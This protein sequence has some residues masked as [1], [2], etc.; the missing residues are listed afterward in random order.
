MN[1]NDWI[2]NRHP[3]IHDEVDGMVEVL[4]GDQLD[5]KIYS[6]KSDIVALDYANGNHVPWRKII[7]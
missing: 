6:I 5:P 3:T 1:N 4:L 7:K 2:F